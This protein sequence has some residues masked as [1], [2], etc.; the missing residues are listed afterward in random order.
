[1][2]A[3]GWLMNLHFAGGTAA[4]TPDPFRVVLSHAVV[5]GAT[6]SHAHTAGTRRQRDREHANVA[7]ATHVQGQPQGGI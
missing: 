3:L 4:V 2:P 1:M 6:D 5:M 7:G